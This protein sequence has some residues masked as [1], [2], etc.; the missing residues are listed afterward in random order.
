M[1][2]LVDLYTIINLKRK[3]KSIKNRNSSINSHLQSIEQF[4]SEIGSSDREKFAVAWLD[5]K[6]N[7]NTFSIVHTGTLN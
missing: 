3:G 1:L 4:S 7:I 6:G 2:K 5:T